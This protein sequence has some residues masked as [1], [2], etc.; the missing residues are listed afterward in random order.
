MSTATG[1]IDVRPEVMDEWCHR[2]LQHTDG[3][4]SDG[5]AAYRQCRGLPPLVEA[6]AR[7]A[8]EA[9]FPH[10]CLPSHGRLLQVLASQISSGIIGETGTGCGVGLA[11]LASGAGPGVGLISID[12]DQERVD[13][14]RRLFA[15]QPDVRIL[16][17]DW[18][19][20]QRHGPFALLTLDG[21]GHGKSGG[22]SISP[23]DW[24]ELGGTLVIDDFTP[25]T[26]WPPTYD[27][28]PDV[29]RMHWLDHPRLSTTDVRT[30]RGA[31]TLVATFR[32]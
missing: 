30:E 9:G 1:L 10:S 2:S 18:P 3:M 20:L 4:S 14:A 13:I 23:E 15:G 29:V 17:G 19:T 21:G 31:C 24:L 16:H 6:A 26:Q 12:N 27:G 5:T 11:W 7:A 25:S 8:A 28:R 32:G 22:A